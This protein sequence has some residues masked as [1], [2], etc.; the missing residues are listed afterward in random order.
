MVQLASH[1]SG[2]GASA[3]HSSK[4]APE[5][6][7]A[8]PEAVLQELVA[9]L[10][11]ENEVKIARTAINEHMFKNIYYPNSE[12][13]RPERPRELPFIWEMSRANLLK[14]ARRL[15]KRYGGPAYELVAWEHGE[16]E[17]K[18]AYRVW[19]QIDFAIREVGAEETIW[20]RNIGSFM[21]YEGGFRFFGIRD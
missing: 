9:G 18:K 4:K 12:I 1:P 11:D 15:V 14:G 21:E 8:S 16:I 3:G 6:W 13:Y 20:V 7:F 19:D 2:H 5:G 17:Q 10:N